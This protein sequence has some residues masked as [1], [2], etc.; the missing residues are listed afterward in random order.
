MECWDYKNH[1]N[2]LPYIYVL[3]NFI[4]KGTNKREKNPVEFTM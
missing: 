1:F 3:K 2:F 4:S